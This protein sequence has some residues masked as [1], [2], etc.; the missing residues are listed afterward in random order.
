[1]GLLGSVL[2]REVGPGSDNFP[3]LDSNN[4]GRTV[5]APDGPAA[6]GWPTVDTAPWPQH[7][8]PGTPMTAATSP[9]VGP[10]TPPIPE[11]RPHVLV[12]QGDERIDD[13]YWLAERDDPAVADP[14][15]GRERL[16]RGR[17]GPTST[18]L[19]ERLYEEIRARIEETDLSVPVRHGPWWYYERTIE[20]SELRRP[21]PLPGGRGRPAGRPRDG[22]RASR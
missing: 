18:P 7:P 5:T 3:Y 21:L 1:M 4:S 12:A 14:P 10:T 13:W 19:R 11:R 8:R 20:G 15:G 16:H 6:P 9:A 22:T 17:P 2:G